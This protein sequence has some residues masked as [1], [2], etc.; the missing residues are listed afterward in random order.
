[1]SRASSSSI[2]SPPPPPTPPQPPSPASILLKPVLLSKYTRLNKKQQRIFWCDNE[3]KILYWTKHKAGDS[4]DEGNYIDEDDDDDE[5]IKRKSTI[6]SPTS[7]TS[8]TS[9][10]SSTSS[11]VSLA[12]LESVHMHPRS[13]TRFLLIF[14]S[15]KLDLES[16]SSSHTSSLISCFQWIY[17]YYHS[18]SRPSN[19]THHTTVTMDLEWKLKP[20]E[21]I[22][23]IFEIDNNT[24]I[25]QIGQ[26][27]K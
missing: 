6:T 27:I 26:G 19:V 3:F 16:S 2:S 21:N 20:G 23:D 7:S 5:D 10:S 11:S 15:R 25:S 18:I 14:S 9:P 12:T 22:S 4:I 13:D 17:S 1:M 24:S 8:P